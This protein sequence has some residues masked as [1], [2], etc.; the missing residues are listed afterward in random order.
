MD[1]PLSIF[2]NIN[3][4]NTKDYIT[5]SKNIYIKNNVQ[6]KNIYVNNNI[7]VIF[8]GEIYNFEKLRDIID[9]SHCNCTKSQINEEPY[10][11]IYELYSKY[12][13]DKTLQLIDGEFYLIVIDID[14]GE[15]YS[16]LYIS[17]DCF[18]KKQIK[19]I[20]YEEKVLEI[21][22]NSNINEEST[23]SII[24][25]P[26]GCYSHYR[27]SYKVLSDWEFYENVKYHLL[28][29]SILHVVDNNIQSIKLEL[30]RLLKTSIT[31]NLK[32]IQ[33]NSIVCKMNYDNTIYNKIQ[34]ISDST[35]YKDNRFD[36]ELINANLSTEEIIENE[37]YK[38]KIIFTDDGFNEI[39]GNKFSDINDPIHFD[40]LTRNMVYDFFLKN[41]LS[42]TKNIKIPYFDREL[43][44]YYFSIP[45]P[46][47]FHKRNN[48]QL[49]KFDT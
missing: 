23:M 10:Y 49:I 7:T 46:I 2:L 1:S 36:V 25:I 40:I 9:I 34:K 18:N 30:K 12:G 26:N 21:T 37:C 41:K 33:C 29:L 5:L 17:Q 6:K 44:Q 8:Q 43:L 38:N 19:T 24:E 15:N 48:S 16:N 39:F 27:L 20:K 22:D 4:I 35:E 14:Y 42:N 3:T 47:R 11:L 45:L 31:N 28:P 13:I 32:N